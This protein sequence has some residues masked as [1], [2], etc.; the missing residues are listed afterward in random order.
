LQLLFRKAFNRGEGIGYLKHA[1]FD[2]VSISAHLEAQRHQQNLI[3][4]N[5]GNC[6][7]SL[8]GALG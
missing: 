7:R 1:T 8:D 5:E 4:G 3:G 2:C 6:K